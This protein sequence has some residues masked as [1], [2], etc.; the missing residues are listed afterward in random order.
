MK[1]EYVFVLLIIIM[2]YMIYIIINYKYNEYIV[3]SRIELLATNNEKIKYRIK[4]KIKDI[5]YKNTKAYKNK[6]LK[7]NQWLKNKAENVVFLIAEDKYDKYT[8][9]NLQKENPILQISQ[10]N[11]NIN[12]MTIIEKWI[13]L[14]LKKDIR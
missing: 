1:K 6:K 10:E 5:E 9:D 4:D 13:Y 12:S 2:L 14:I 8:K 7:E 3:N 11:S